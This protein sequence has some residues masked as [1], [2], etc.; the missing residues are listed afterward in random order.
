VP[1]RDESYIQSVLERSDCFQGRIANR[2]QVQIQINFPQHQQ[3]V[4]IFKGWWKDGM[5]K[6]RERND[7]DA[8][9]VFLCELGPPPHAI[10]DANQDELSN[11]WQESLQIRD[12]VRE[13]WSEL[14]AE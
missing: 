4:D 9:L 3:W 6:W 14:E 5:A 13:I 7:D 2:E 11:R 10:T 8:T 12:W 1:E